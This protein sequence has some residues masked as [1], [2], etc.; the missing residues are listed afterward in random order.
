MFLSLPWLLS[1]SVKV[2]VL[3]SVQ[4]RRDD[5][6]TAVGVVFDT[7]EARPNRNACKGM[8]PIVLGRVESGSSNDWWWYGRMRSINGRNNLDNSGFRVGMQPHIMAIWTSA[9]DQLAMV[10]RCHVASW[11]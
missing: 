7:L 9:L 10:T 1:T 3:P 8:D 2:T 5:W 4:D 6:P 11:T